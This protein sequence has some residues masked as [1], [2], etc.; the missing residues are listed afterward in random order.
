MVATF[1][2][3]DAQVDRVRQG[4]VTRRS[5]VAMANELGVAPSTVRRYIKRIRDEWRKSAIDVNAMQA[6]LYGRAEE[7]YHTNMRMGRL[8]EARECL[9]LLMRL[10]GAASPERKAVEVTGAGGAPIATRTEIVFVQAQPQ[11]QPQPLP[12]VEQPALPP[13]QDSDVMAALP[14]FVSA[15]ETWPKS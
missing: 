6:E 11:P 8:R 5:A 1:K 7:L 10:T 14:V 4:M 15:D 9:A 3:D 2:L 13:S 12:V